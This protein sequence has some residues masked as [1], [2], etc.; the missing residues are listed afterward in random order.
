LQAV[1]PRA[2][3]RPST[4]AASF[5]VRLFVFMPGGEANRLPG[6]VPR[7]GLARAR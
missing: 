4:I 7:T 6:S 5:L 1:A 2:A 3:L